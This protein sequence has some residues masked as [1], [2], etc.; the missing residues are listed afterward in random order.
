MDQLLHSPKSMYASEKH[1][2]INIYSCP[3]LVK[4]LAWIRYLSLYNLKLHF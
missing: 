1:D 4:L 2:I 3:I